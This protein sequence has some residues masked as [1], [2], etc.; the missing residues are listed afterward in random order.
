MRQ[1]AASTKAR[2]DLRAVVV[3]RL[4]PTRTDNAQED[5]GENDGLV[6]EALEAET[7]KPR[8]REKVGCGADKA[9]R[10]GWCT[11][12]HGES[13]LMHLIPLKKY[14]IHNLYRYYTC[15]LDV[16]SEVELAE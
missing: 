8:N 14:E 2:Q 11:S 15:L 5:G 16:A 6:V 3:V 13:F 10:C 4:K 1:H 9:C 12:R 7:S